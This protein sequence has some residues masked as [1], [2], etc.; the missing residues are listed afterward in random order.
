M[1]GEIFKDSLRKLE[2]KPKQK[3]QK[4]TSLETR[5]NSQQIDT[6]IVKNDINIITKVKSQR[7]MVY[8]NYRK[9]YISKLILNKITFEKKLLSLIV[10]RHTNRY[11]DIS[12]TKNLIADLE[13]KPPKTG[14]ETMEKNL[15]KKIS[16]LKLDR[17]PFILRYNRANS[18]NENFNRN[19]K[20]TVYYEEKT[21]CNV[22]EYMK[23]INL[24]KLSNDVIVVF[25]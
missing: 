8:K 24:S 1:G 19:I 12:N 3:F 10:N 11:K 4:I 17:T 22:A 5:E 7:N 23:K 25:C 18:A 2:G 6:N 14:E 21:N 16:S 20:N 15:E 13:H 9:E